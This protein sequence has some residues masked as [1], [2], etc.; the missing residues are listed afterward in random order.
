L[1]LFKKK[2]AFKFDSVAASSWGVV[3]FRNFF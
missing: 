2:L 3:Y 1:Y